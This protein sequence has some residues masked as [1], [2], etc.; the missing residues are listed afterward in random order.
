[1]EP[2]GFIA[3]LPG[4]LSLTRSAATAFFAPMKFNIDGRFVALPPSLLPGTP[5]ARAPFSPPLS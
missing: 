3:F 4:D 1:M 2:D 5:L